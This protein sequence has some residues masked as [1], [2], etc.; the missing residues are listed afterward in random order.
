MVWK[1]QFGS[2]IMNERF[3]VVSSR[4]RQIFK[5]WFFHVAV[6]QT[7]AKKCTKYV[8]HVQHD[9][10]LTSK[11]IILFLS[12]VVVALAVVVE[13]VQERTTARAAE[14][15]QNNNIIGLK[16]KKNRTE[17]AARILLLYLA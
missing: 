17:R 7:T 5:S 1:E 9:P 12:A 16:R 13:G 10:F 15:P 8:S 6:L 4:G 14:T 2:K 11:P 3:T